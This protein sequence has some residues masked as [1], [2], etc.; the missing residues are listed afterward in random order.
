MRR[1]CRN[2]DLIKN[3]IKNDS[4]RSI[5]VDTSDLEVILKGWSAEGEAGQS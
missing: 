3:I 2:L 5:Y 4:D 1:C